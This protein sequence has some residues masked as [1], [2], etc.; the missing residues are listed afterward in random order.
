MLARLHRWAALIAAAS[1]LL[2]GC[3]GP[4]STSA[5]AE[6]PTT[7]VGPLPEVVIKTPTPVGVVPTV[8]RSKDPTTFTQVQASDLDTLDP[9]VS[10]D[11]NTAG[12]LQNVYET[13][14]FF[15]KDS[16]TSF[17]PQLAEEVPSLQNGGISPDGLTYTFKIRQG[18]KFHN[19]DPL[20]PADVAYSLQRGLL[21]GGSNSLAWVMFE[22]LFGTT[23]NDDITDLVDTSGAVLDSPQKLATASSLYRRAACQLVQTQITSNAAKGTVTIHLNQPWGPFLMILTN[24]FTSIEDRKWVV[25]N[26]GWDGSCE[27]W[28][29]YYNPTADQQNQLGVGHSANGTGPYM[30]DHWT[31][32][33]EIVLKANPKYWRK[34]PAWPGGPTGVAALKT[35]NIQIEK[36][37]SARD[38]ALKSGAADTIGFYASSKQTELDRIAGEVCPIGGVCQTGPIPA[39]KVRVYTGLAADTRLDA[40]F[41]FAINTYGGNNLIGSGVLDGKGIPPNFFSDVHVRQAFSY[42]FDWDAFIQGGLNGSGRQLFQVMLPGEI[43]ASDQN[44]HY[45]HDLAACANAFKA[46]VWRSAAGRALWDVGFVMSLAPNPKNPA[47]QAFAQIMANQLTAL[48]PKFQVTVNNLAWEDYQNATHAKKLPI[49]FAVSHE[50]IADP[51]NWADL[52]TIGSLGS[53]QQMPPGMKYQFTGLVQKGVETSDP[54][55]RAQVYQQFNQ[56]FYQNASAIL[57]AQE[58]QRRYEQRWVNG[59]YYNPLY[60]DLYYYVLSKS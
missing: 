59:Y 43:G 15:N 52:M 54:A 60:A 20:T 38:D 17:V 50:L 27:T 2:A 3:G 23:A 55:A 16:V 10:V 32:G 44:P 51:H 7:T 11:Q 45:T 12:V 49:Y 36:R 24:P 37:A 8:F 53:A 34:D 47:S 9:V 19:G 29:K 13:L 58:F 14:V 26:G 28:Q 46:S 57:L 48:N 35:I 41:N 42:C 33:Q 5:P 21:S 30:V 39:N 25:A 40:L 31:S 22:P 6:E 56:L 1:L 18:I 4:S